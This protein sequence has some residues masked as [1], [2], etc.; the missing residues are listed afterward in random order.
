VVRVHYTTPT[1]SGS[2]GSPVFVEHQWKAAAFHH[3]GTAETRKLNGK[4]GTYKPNEG[5][6]F[7]STSD[8]HASC[9][10]LEFCF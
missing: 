3:Y 7:A 8:A 9:K 5:I 1:E 10:G 6:S 2:S 4:S